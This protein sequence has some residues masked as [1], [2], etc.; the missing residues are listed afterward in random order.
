M[1]RYLSLDIFCSLKLTVFLELRSWKTVRFAEQIMSADK[2][3]S[4]FSCQMEAIVYISIVSIRFSIVIN[5]LTVTRFLWATFFTVFTWLTPLATL[6]VGVFI[7]EFYFPAKI[8]L[9]CP[10]LAKISRNNLQ[11]FVD[12]AGL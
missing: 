11:N 1:L 3:L 12:Q 5:C 4:I 7:G 8:C 2:Y 9:V 6:V 10:L